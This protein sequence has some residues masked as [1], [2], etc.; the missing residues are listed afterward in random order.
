MCFFLQF[1]Y[2]LFTLKID[3][4]LACVSDRCK[5][6]ATSNRFGRDKYLLCLNCFSSS[7]NCCDVNAVRGLLVLPSIACGICSPPRNNTEEEIERKN[8]L[9]YRKTKI[10]SNNLKLTAHQMDQQ[11][12]L[13]KWKFFLVFCYKGNIYLQACLNCKLISAE[14]YTARTKRKKY[15]TPRTWRRQHKI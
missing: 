15:C 13:L 7:S 1:I 14:E 3:I 2:N 4:L 10:K 8:K 9:K 11:Y 5:Q 12:T 6:L